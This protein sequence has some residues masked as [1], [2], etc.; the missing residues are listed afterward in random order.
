[1][2]KVKTFRAEYGCSAEINKTWHRFHCAIELEMEDGDAVPDIK[3]RA[4]NT[5]I[6]EVEKQIKETLK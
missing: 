1:M 5:V 4:W 2:A 6:S 3:D